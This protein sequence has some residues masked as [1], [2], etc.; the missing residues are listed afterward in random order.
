MNKL[1]WLLVSIVAVL[2]LTHSVWAGE[3]M[4]DA[5]VIF[6]SR[7]AFALG[8]GFSIYILYAFVRKVTGKSWPALKIWVWITAAVIAVH[9]SYTFFNP[10]LKGAWL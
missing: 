6:V 1:V 8:A 9:L 10:G 5:V 4:F 2:L 3:R 7:F